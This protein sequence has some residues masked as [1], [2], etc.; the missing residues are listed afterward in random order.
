M[1]GGFLRRW[2][3]RRRAIRRLWQQ[4][5]R[6]LISRDERSAYYTA[7]RLAARARAEGDRASL[8]HWVKVAAEVARASPVAEMDLSVVDSSLLESLI[9]KLWDHHGKGLIAHST[10]ASGLWEVG[11]QHQRRAEKV[12]FR[13]SSSMP[14]ALPRLSLG[15][16][17]K[18]A[19]DIERIRRPL[20]L[21]FRGAY[22]RGT[23]V[24]SG[25]SALARPDQR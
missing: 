18:L 22:P 21:L 15:V 14:D 23:T 5:A 1:T 20:N 25:P 2:I 3:E 24:V 11:S 8:V 16:V 4:D 10:Y 19:D 6:E 12:S 7:Q 17:P 9:A 13:A